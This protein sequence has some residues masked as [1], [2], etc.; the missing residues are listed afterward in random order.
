MLLLDTNIIS[1]LLKQ[2]SRATLY[3]AI[4][5]SDKAHAISLMTVAELFQ[6]ADERQWGQ[7]RR[8][9]LETWLNQN[10]QI[11][12][13]EYAICETWAK[14]RV[15]C[16]AKGQ[17]IE[18]AD[19]WIAATAIYHQIPLVTHNVKDFRCI[20]QLKLGGPP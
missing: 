11:L 12:P 8:Q 3:Q 18:V 19:A 9:M 4:L 14:I 6:W 13:L 2:D 17:R 15:E 16:Q 7:P 10:Y 1:Y 5:S 20:S